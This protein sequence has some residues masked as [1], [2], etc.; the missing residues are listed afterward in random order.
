MIATGFNFLFVVR[1]SDQ[2]VL[3]FF[4][5]EN[6]RKMNKKQREDASRMVIKRKEELGKKFHAQSYEI[7]VGVGTEKERNKVI[8]K[9]IESAFPN[10]RW[11]WNEIKQEM[12]KT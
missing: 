6:I 1:K 3:Q 10:F 11:N 5:S 9:T 4:I 12:L 2:N 8:Q 7:I